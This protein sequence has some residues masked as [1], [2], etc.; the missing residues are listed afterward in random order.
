MNECLQSPTAF[1]YEVSS[2]GKKLILDVD[3]NRVSFERN[4]YDP[5]NSKFFYRLLHPRMIAQVGNYYYCLRQRPSKKGNQI[6]YVPNKRYA[7]RDVKRT[8]AQIKISVLPSRMWDE[9]PLAVLTDKMLHPYTEYCPCVT[10]DYFAM[11]TACGIAHIPYSAEIVY[12][13]GNNNAAVDASAK[14]PRPMVDNIKTVQRL[15][16]LGALNNQDKQSILALKAIVDE[17][18]KIATAEKERMP[19]AVGQRVI[20]MYLNRWSSISKA[21][22]YVGNPYNVYG[23]TVNNLPPFTGEG[24]DKKRKASRSLSHVTTPG[25]EE[26]VQAEEETSPQQQAE[27]NSMDR[28]N[29]GG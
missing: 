9:L 23:R 6:E 7:Y 8:L 18:I 24:E 19:S 13:P 26:E 5:S 11:E 17:Q 10:L 15:Q 21:L 14:A 28:Q 27:D 1:M 22:E 4:A 12:R 25:Q 29:P 2:E 16:D 3:G 20:R